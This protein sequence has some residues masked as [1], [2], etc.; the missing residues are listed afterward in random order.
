MDM[1]IL[2]DDLLP[3]FEGVADFFMDYLVVCYTAGGKDCVLSTGDKKD[4]SK[5]PME[6][7]TGPT[8]SPENA[9]EFKTNP[10]DTGKYANVAFTPAIDAS[11]L[12]QVA[13]AYYL[14]TTYLLGQSSKDSELARHHLEKGL[15]SVTC[16]LSFVPKE[17]ISQR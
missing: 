13:N 9:F 7:H 17:V 12:R 5:V 10:R 11:V 4:G 1:T 8:T 14:A 15:Q 16:A 3:A 6:Y 2:K